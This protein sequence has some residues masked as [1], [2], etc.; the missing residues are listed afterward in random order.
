VFAGGAGVHSLVVAACADFFSELASRTSTLA[1]DTPTPFR[2]D[3]RAIANRLV[4]AVTAADFIA[5]ASPLGRADYSCPA[6]VHRRR[7]PVV[8]F[9]DR[10]SDTV[11]VGSTRLLTPIATDEY[12]TDSR[13]HHR[14]RQSAVSAAL[15]A[16][17]Y[18]CTQGD[19]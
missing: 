16:R 18:C 4:G 15:I 8:L 5:A 3:D 17:G 2:C 19:A 6:T 7:W 12:R 11:V 14:S 13:G 9:A 1:A 10:S